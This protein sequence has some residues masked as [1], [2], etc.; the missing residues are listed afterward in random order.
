MAEAA[1]P[2]FRLVVKAPPSWRVALQAEALA[3]LEP[4][5]LASQPEMLSV[6]V[7]E[8]TVPKLL[9]AG[10]DLLPPRAHR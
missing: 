1:W 6:A 4:L 5:E 2:E 10:S 8:L 7:E 3:R 9:A